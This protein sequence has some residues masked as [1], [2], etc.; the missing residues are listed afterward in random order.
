[1]NSRRLVAASSGRGPHPSMSMIESHRRR[2]GGPC[3]ASFVSQGGTIGM[4][5]GPWPVASKACA[6]RPSRIPLTRVFKTQRGIASAPSSSR[7]LDAAGPA[8]TRVRSYVRAGTPPYLRRELVS[9]RE[10]RLISY[11]ATA[12]RPSRRSPGFLGR[13][14][15][16]F[17][18]AR[19]RPSLLRLVRKRLSWAK[20]KLWRRFK[21]RSTRRRHPT[22]PASAGC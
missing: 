20:R 18:E 19:R 1:M 15:Q 8:G 14:S 3:L 22:A 6:R 2:L 4:R 10:P 12:L 17:T 5:Q 7:T 21:R 16:R 13:G 9:R 11:E